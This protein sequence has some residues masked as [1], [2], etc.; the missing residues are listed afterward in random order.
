MF[1]NNMVNTQCNRSAEEQYRMTTA[2]STAS[3]QIFRVKMLLGKWK[4]TTTY[5]LQPE[6]PYPHSQLN[7]SC[8]S[9]CLTNIT[10]SNTKWKTKTSHEFQCITVQSHAKILVLEPGMCGEVLFRKVGELWLE[11]KDSRRFTA[12]FT[13]VNNWM[14]GEMVFLFQPKVHR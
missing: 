10:I 13:T 2:P 4:W 5:N 9:A 7:P 6:P 1:T 12:A 3:Q 11:W 14:G 8:T